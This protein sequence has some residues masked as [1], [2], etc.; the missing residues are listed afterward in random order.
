MAFVRGFE[1]DDYAPEYGLIVLRDPAGGDEGSE[2]A[3]TFAGAGARW[4]TSQA[5]SGHHTVR[6]EL[7]DG[8]PPAGDFRDSMETPYRAVSG[9]LTL[10]VLTGGGGGPVH[11]DLG[12]PG[13][14]RVRVTRSDDRWLLQFWPGPGPGLPGWHARSR[15]AAGPGNSG[16]Q[17]ELE[18]APMELAGVV[19][20]AAREHGG[21]V[22]A[23]QVDAWGRAHHRPPGWLDEP[24]W[25]PPRAPLTTGHADLDRRNADQRAT[26]LDR[27]ARSRRRLDEIAAEL[28]VPP[29]ARRRDALP[30]LA[31]AGI[32]NQ[33]QDRYA[34][35]HPA[36][37]DTVLSLPPERVRGVRWQD[38]R[39]RYGG[40]AEDLQSLLRWTTEPALEVTAAA[41]AARLLV[42]E[43]D[44]RAALAFAE[45]S[46]LLHT[47]GGDPLRLSPG[48]RPT[49]PPTA[50]TAPTAPPPPPAP[51][52]PPAPPAPTAPPPPRAPRPAS[53]HH[54]DRPG[55]TITGF[56]TPLSGGRREEPPA[57]PFGAPPRA[58]VV[59]AD[60]AVLVW[61]DGEAVE[62]ARLQPARAARALET[63]A[64]VLVVA[65]GHPARLISAGGRVTEVDAVR[66]QVLAVPGDGRR[67][68]VVDSEYH[69]RQSRYRLLVV[70]LESGDVTTM[71]WPADRGIGV[72]GAYRDS[73]FF[74]EQG[75]VFRWTPGSEPVVVQHPVREVDPV[76]GATCGRTIEGAAVT[77]A[78]GGTVTLPV[79]A[80][81][82]LAAGGAALWTVRSHPPALTLFP[83]GAAPEVR[84]RVFW[85]PED[86]RRSPQ[87]TY[88]APVWEDE[89]HVLFGHPPW[90]FPRE[91]SIGVRLSLADGAVERLPAAGRSVLLVEP[92]LRTP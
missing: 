68:A 70:D 5:G 51:T 25:P 44:L 42:P 57:P 30:L 90:H 7:H 52:A 22:T 13:D 17:T 71:P 35:G 82:R 69:R 74:A 48:R 11:L 79:E 38:A 36:R 85:L 55:H 19:S 62:L 76:S 1:R 16:W 72:L 78:D 73:V 86:G 8:P 87:G 92:W 14:Y 21:P 24:M 83:V 66:Q 91:P 4:L 67:V 46:G 29:V 56:F 31:A 20:A 50:P 53:P 88:S 58:G 12:A 89:G 28:G 26:V 84:P 64:G 33:Q 27:L 80:G 10:T 18:Y 61:R 6:L 40:L 63:R 59:R 23:D 37:V 81:A 34:A 41:L 60:G 75:E 3:G 32:L 65:H 54:S 45:E 39:S 49:P 77:R 2:P 47:G 43:A 15:P 9:E